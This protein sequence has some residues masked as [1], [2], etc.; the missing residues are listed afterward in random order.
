MA[1][2]ILMSTDD[3]V[4]I[5][6]SRADFELVAE[7]VSELIYELTHYMLQPSEHGGA[8][9]QRDVHPKV[10]ELQR[11]YDLFGAA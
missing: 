1:E 5:T 6:L 10:A 2:R 11:I 8:E 9:K 3:V 4:T 7:A